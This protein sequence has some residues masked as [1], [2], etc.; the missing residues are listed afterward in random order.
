MKAVLSVMLCFIVWL[1]TVQAPP[2]FG[3]T[4]T[5]GDSTVRA[6]AAPEPS[7]PGRPALPEE[8]PVTGSS[9]ADATPLGIRDFVRLVR[10]K[11]EQIG[12]QD[13]EWAISRVSSTR[14][15]F[16]KTSGAIRSRNS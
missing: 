8:P 9:V 6:E 2:A 16:R 3:G 5:T 4:M 14:T 1:A 7:V 13:A 12:Y 10:E 15:S 11:N